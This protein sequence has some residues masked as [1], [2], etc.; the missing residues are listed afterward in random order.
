MARQAAS[1]PLHVLKFR[2]IH[3]RLNLIGFIALLGLIVIGGL[4]VGSLYQ[5][6]MAER[7]LNTRS[8]V[9]TALSV[10]AHFEAQERAGQL[11]HEAAQQAAMAAVA[12]L[13]Y[14]DGNYFWINDAA[15]RIVMH[16]IQPK[17]NGSDG[18][19]ILDKDGVSPFRRA[20]EATEG[21]GRGEFAYRWPKPGGGDPVP[22]VSYA[23]RFAPWGWIV[24]TGIYVDDISATIRAVVFWSVAEF[25]V[26]AAIIGAAL[27]ALT[28]SVNRPL[29]AMTEA[30]TRLADGDVTIVA[31]SDRPLDEIRRMEHALASLKHVVCEMFELRQMVDQ[32]PTNVIAARMPDL[33]VTY[34]NNGS[35][36]LLARLAEDGFS[37]CAPDALMGRSIDIFHGDR[38]REI[39]EL[40]S[41][42]AN[43][44]H[45]ARIRLGPEHIYQRISA[46]FGADGTYVG[47]MLVW[48][49]VTAQEQ[50]A[51]DV[52]TVTQQILGD[53]GRLEHD[54]IRMAETA[55]TTAGQVKD[56]ARASD[57]AASS[58]QAMAAA[59]E[60]LSASIS[61]IGER[62]REASDAA[63]V[64]RTTTEH[65]D[66]T[67]RG[68][69][70]SADEIGTIVALIGDIAGQTNLLALNATIEAAR[71]GEAGKGFAVVASEVKA[72]AGQ[73]AKAT[74]EIADQ[75]GGMR[76]VTA[77]VVAALQEV[78]TTVLAIHDIAGHINEAMQQQSQAT[79]EIARGAAQAADGTRRASA[80][81][82]GLLQS[83]ADTGEGANDVL[84][85]ATRFVQG[86]ETLKQRLAEFVTSM[87]AA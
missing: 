42:P 25:L 39:S 31:G 36:R 68:L 78:S 71:A 77:Q 60:E 17:L 83:A 76:S 15:G 8:E 75:V 73:T 24:A 32:M 58:V 56:A 9:D 63:R 54:S 65:L 14:G 33:R 84:A 47:P 2:S 29:S 23:A 26:V 55:E 22:K 12:A 82:E 62:M 74:T 34:M 38:T 67:A 59:A 3:S 4:G 86:S 5:H 7:F 10:L 53:T 85:I 79:S 69:T 6:L 70:R 30:M 18:L 1:G 20:I 27:L 35:K 66:L 41:N 28:R 19:R 11:T 64:A 46:V 87:R 52:D 61:A 48:N 37:N 45:A 21:G 40:L 50:L 44:P 72:L 43:L 57:E 16:P 49:V 81:F 13:R 51:V 80:S